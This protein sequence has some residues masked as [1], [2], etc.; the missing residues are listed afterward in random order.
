MEFGIITEGKEVDETVLRYTPVG[1]QGRRNIEALVKLDQSVEELLDEC[2][3]VNI[4]G[5]GWIEISRAPREGG[6]VYASL[7]RLWLGLVRSF[8]GLL[9]T[10]GGEAQ[11]KR[12]QQ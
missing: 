9:L 2:H 4:G 8:G 5:K 1:G 3:R 11:E 6:T 10:T 7:S 12:K